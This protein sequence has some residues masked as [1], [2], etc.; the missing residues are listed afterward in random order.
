MNRTRSTST[1]GECRDC[2]ASWDRNAIEQA[3]RHA[4]TRGHRTRAHRLQEYD[5]EPT[6]E[7]LHGQLELP[8]R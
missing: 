2:P 7:E 4:R 6:R 1:A 8:A 3:Q 5:W